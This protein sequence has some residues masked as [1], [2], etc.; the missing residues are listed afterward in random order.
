M[1]SKYLNRAKELFSANRKY[2]M[3]ISMS[4]SAWNM[5]YDTMCQLAEESY[6]EGFAECSKLMYSITD[7]E[8]L[9]K[10]KL[11]LILS[12]AES[13]KQKHD[14]NSLCKYNG[15]YIRFDWLKDTIQLHTNTKSNE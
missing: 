4:E 7:V 2:D 9:I 14:T 6:K 12:E 15:D 8:E 13:I 1:E 10:S 3:I 11:N 5:I